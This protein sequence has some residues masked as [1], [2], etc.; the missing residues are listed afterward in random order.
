MIRAVKCAG[1]ILATR[2]IQTHLFSVMMLGVSVFLSMRLTKV[3]FMPET[4]SFAQYQAIIQSK[5]GILLLVAALV[6]LF[7]QIINLLV[8]LLQYDQVGIPVTFALM[9]TGFL[10]PVKLSFLNGRPLF[11]GLFFLLLVATQVGVFGATVFTAS[12]RLLCPANFMSA[13]SS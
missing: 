12:A 2:R 3:M 5:S 8:A 1:Q 11:F 7:L 4:L 10:V 6:A 13:E 9:H